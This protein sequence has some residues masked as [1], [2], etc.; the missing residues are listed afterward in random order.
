M[1]FFEQRDGE[2]RWLRGDEFADSGMR[3][4]GLRLRESKSWRGD[5]FKEETQEN[6]LRLG[7]ED[8]SD[9]GASF[10]RKRG[11]RERENRRCRGEV[12]RAETRAL[13]RVC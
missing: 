12:P 9:A 3:K 7:G 8:K 2:Q 1:Y 11:L 13:L 10:W 5:D 6:R 4:E